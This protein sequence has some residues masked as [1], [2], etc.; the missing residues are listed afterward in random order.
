MRGTRTARVDMLARWSERGERARETESRTRTGGGGGTAYLPVYLSACSRAARAK[1]TSYTSELA[2][3]YTT[4]SSARPLARSL[5]LSPPPLA[6]ACVVVVRAYVR[7]R[8]DGRCATHTTV[9]VTQ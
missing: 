8:A 5:S 4:V 1:S 2:R 9:P 6:R 3:V 7:T